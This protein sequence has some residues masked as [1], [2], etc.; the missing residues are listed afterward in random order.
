MSSKN[1][2]DIFQSVVN[3]QFS[4][5]KKAVRLILCPHV[6]SLQ[7]VTQNINT[8][9]YN[10]KLQYY[11]WPISLV[12]IL[13]YNNISCVICPKMAFNQ[14]FHL[15]LAFNCQYLAFKDLAHIMIYGCVFDSKQM[16]IWNLLHKCNFKTKPTLTNFQIHLD[17]LEECLQLKR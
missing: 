4:V 12:Y 14:I 16:S 13:L 9:Y 7:S 11:I 1:I 5:T 8:V 10:V 2:Y 17:H 6:I 3:V 15:I